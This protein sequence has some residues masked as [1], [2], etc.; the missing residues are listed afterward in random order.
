MKFYDF[1]SFLFDNKNQYHTLTIK[2]KKEHGFMLN[3]IFGYKYPLI[4]ELLNSTGIPENYI[5]DYWFYNKI[6]K[7]TRIPKYF[8]TSTKK[9]S[10]IL[11]DVDTIRK[12]CIHNFISLTDF[13]YLKKFCK[14][15]LVKDLEHFK[16]QI[17]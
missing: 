6:K 16:E 10:N 3:K 15:D 5:V 11:Y 8:F 12:Y 7:E 14:E 1:V 4:S 2:E 17:S 13:N 9:D